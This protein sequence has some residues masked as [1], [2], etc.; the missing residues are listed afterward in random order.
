MRTFRIAALLVSLTAAG[1]AIAQDRAKS[2]ASAWEIG[3]VIQG[4]NYSVGTPPA[5][6]RRRGGGLQIDI[7]PAPGSVHYV[8][9]SHGSLENMSR[10]VMRYRVEMAPGAQIVPT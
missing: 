6:T 2:P 10:I 7:P 3:P 1:T 8:T 4:E 5:P 9:F